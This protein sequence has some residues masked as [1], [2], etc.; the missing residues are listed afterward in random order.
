MADDAAEADEQ[1]QLGDEEAEEGDGRIGQEAGEQYGAAAADDL[2]EVHLQ[3]DDEKEKDEAE[4][5]DGVDVFGIGDQAQG[6]RP[7]HD[8]GQDVAGD[9]R[10]VQAGEDDRQNAGQND[11]DA[12]IVN[13]S[14]H[15]AFRREGRRTGGNGKHKGDQARPQ[16]PRKRPRTAHQ[17]GR[18]L[19]CVPESSSAVV[20]CMYAPRERRKPLPCFVKIVGVKTEMVELLSISAMPVLS[21]AVGTRQRFIRRSCCY[22]SAVGLSSLPVVVATSWHP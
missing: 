5:G 22:G 11:A 4:L 9:C 19:L 13:Q 20:A 14:R 2:A 15:G 10:Q 8:T 12:D 17:Q 6:E 18:L 7:G 21:A 1:H 3:T 16:A